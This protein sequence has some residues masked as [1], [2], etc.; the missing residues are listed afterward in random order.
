MSFTYIKNRSGLR[1]NPWGVPALSFNF[2]DISS[3]ILTGIVLSEINDYNKLTILLGNSWLISLYLRP[4]C[5][6]E[7]KAFSTSIKLATPS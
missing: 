3:L 2:S 7:S 1:T 5:H 6:T 4:L